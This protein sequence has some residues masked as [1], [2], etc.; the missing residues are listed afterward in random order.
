MPPLPVP[1]HGFR[2]RLLDAMRGYDRQRFASDFGAGITVGVVALPLA[3]AFAIASGLKPE[4]GLIT[5]IVGGLI[6]SLLGGSNVQIGGPAGA[7]IVIVYAILQRYGLTNLL[8][9]TA[10]AGVLLFALGLFRFGALVRVIPVP[11]IIGFTNGI[12]VLIA[13]SQLKDLL[14][15]PIAAMPADF[16]AQ[17]GTLWAH[18]G[19]VNVHALV[20]GVACIAVLAL[21]ARLPRGVSARLPAPV[22]ALAAATLVAWAFALPLETIG[23]RFG[24]IP[25]TLPT[26][27]LPAFSWESAKQ[28]VT[29]TLTI[30]LLGAVESLLCA[31]IADN[32][33]PT[34]L[35]HDPNQELMGQGVAN[36]VSPL[37]GGMP[38]TGT[39]ARTLTNVRAGA[40]TPVAGVVHAL[41][42][43]AVVLLAAPLAVHVPLAALAGILL[44]VAWNMVEWHEFARLR[45]FSVPYRT[46]LLGSF[47]LTVVF[48]LTVAVEVGLVLACLFFIYRMGTLFRAAP[49]APA[50]APE[51]VQLYALYGSLF[52]G[53]V[54]KLEALAESLPAGTRAVVFDLHRLVSIDTSGLDA[55]TQLKRT[56]DRQGVVL[57]LADLNDQPRSLIQRAGFDLELGEAGLAATP[58][59]ALDRWRQAPS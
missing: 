22:V 47:F 32:A 9:S 51:G 30:A 40:T 23:S 37:F 27:A 18:A 31:R 2:P 11:I 20:L 8:I 17:I 50:D 14:G 21:W 53:A 13:V 7:F 25:S 6:V 41:A 38:V 36:M 33:A 52:F 42:L 48:D 57:V 3:M 46:I 58:A 56:L 59:Q 28:L 35:R 54:G 43:L 44:F 45:R 15:L 1:L 39:I 55:L 16:F 29:P 5:A 24:G 19:Q 26:L 12:A 10:L 34:L 49:L 4:Q